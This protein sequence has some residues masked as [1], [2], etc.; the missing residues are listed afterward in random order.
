MLGYSIAEKLT[1]S[2]KKTLLFL[3]DIQIGIRISIWEMQA[4][5]SAFL[6][7]ILTRAYPYLSYL[8]VLLT[9]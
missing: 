5:T 8:R 3:L 1:I 2:I 4:D 6:F 9:V 7:Q